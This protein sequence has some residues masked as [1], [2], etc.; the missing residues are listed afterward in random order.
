VLAMV[1]APVLAPMLSPVEAPARA[2]VSA[3]LHTLANEPPLGFALALGL[4]FITSTNSNLQRFNSTSK[5]WE[6]PPP[7]PPVPPPT[8][9]GTPDR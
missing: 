1:L 4:M 9:L 5:L 2:Q 3:Y 7:V 6:K 8:G